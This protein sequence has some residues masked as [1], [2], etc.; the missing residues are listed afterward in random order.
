MKKLNWHRENFRI[1]SEYWVGKNKSKKEFLLEKY[2]ASQNENELR[3]NCRRAIS[4]LNK[5]KALSRFSFLLDDF[6]FQGKG[7]TKKTYGVYLR[8]TKFFYLWTSFNILFMTKWNGD[9][10]NKKGRLSEIDLFLNYESMI[11]K[12]IQKKDYEE[13][14][15]YIS[16]S[17]KNIIE[18]F[19]NIYTKEKLKILKEE[20][21][22]DGINLKKNKGLEYLPKEQAN[23]KS[24]NVIKIK[25]KELKIELI[26]KV[27]TI[28]DFLYFCYVYRN[29]IAHGNATANWFGE[30]G[31]DSRQLLENLY[32]GLSYYLFYSI[33]FLLDEAINEKTQNTA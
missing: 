10:A 8:S 26:N 28:P 19:K 20:D 21:Y 29:Q 1:L 5:Y 14:E 6:K 13:L 33:N 11:Q 7:L 25:S 27:P 9:S 2:I 3:I 15:K 24:N 4:N 16:V 17:L 31:N 30:Y 23:L 32:N 22:L 12:N 18:N